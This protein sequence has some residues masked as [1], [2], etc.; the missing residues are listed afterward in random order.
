MSSRHTDSL[1]S[2]TYRFLQAC[3]IGRHAPQAFD[4]ARRLVVG[5]MV[6]WEALW[7]LACEERVASLLYHATRRKDLIPDALA[8]RGR[9]YYLET[10]LINALRLSDLAGTLTLLN[11][12]GIDVIVLK[13]AALAEG[14]YKNIGLRPMM[15]VDILVHKAQ[16]PHALDVLT[17]AGFETLGPAIS[18]GATLAYE[19]EIA[20]RRPSGSGGYLELHWAL[21][22]SPF[23][24]DRI[25]EDVLWRT[26][27]PF[28]VCG[29]Q[30]HV[31]APD[32]QL[33]HLCGH[34]QLHHKGRG[35]LWWQDVVELLVRFR[36]RF[37]WDHV[38]VEAG[39]L[40]MVLP[41][42]GILTTAVDCWRAPV[43]EDVLERVAL[44]VPSAAEQQVVRRMMTSN[45]SSA[46][47]LQSDLAT[48]PDA[49]QRA[50]FLYHNLFP[51]TAYMDER[52]GITRPVLRPIYYFR[53]W[54]TGLAGLVPGSSKQL[55]RQ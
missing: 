9:Q 5:E 42:Q 26:A 25:P 17:H 31:L 10:G 21:F 53:R 14:L 18:P 27:E 30:A 45:Q 11:G 28:D 13:G 40:E 38:L 37:N 49:R 44:L 43:S 46:R 32:M 50:R 15:D 55:P 7:T 47:R 39:A 3:L 6:D 48:L 52:Y 12:K 36:E 1:D 34:L 2:D 22:D 41:L 24:Q 23:Y 35:L 33:L 19:N 16:A 54:L 51:S 29:T 8:E 20:L 4:D